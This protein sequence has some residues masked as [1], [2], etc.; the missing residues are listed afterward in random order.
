MTVLVQA[1]T[2]LHQWHPRLVQDLD[3]GGLRAFPPG[4]EA[5]RRGERAVAGGL[6]GGV[7][8]EAGERLRERGLGVHCLAARAQ[9]RGCVV[10]EVAQ[11]VEQRQ[12]QLGP[13]LPGFRAQIPLVGAAVAE[14]PQEGREP[15]VERGM[16]VGQAR[17]QAVHPTVER[18]CE[19]RVAADDPG[20][21]PEREGGGG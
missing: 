18:G 9:D 21:I 15:Y 13:G 14:V 8:T 3:A 2:E 7:P 17:D 1:S 19:P 20:E 4:A 12:R 11:P 5:A 10:V 6:R 16:D